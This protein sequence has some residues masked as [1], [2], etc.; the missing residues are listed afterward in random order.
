MISLP[1]RFQSF[2]FQ[3]LSGKLFAAKPLPF[4]IYQSIINGKLNTTTSFPLQAHI[5]ILYVA[6]KQIQCMILPE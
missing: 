5:T 4:I 6:Y 3:F 2:F 1:Y